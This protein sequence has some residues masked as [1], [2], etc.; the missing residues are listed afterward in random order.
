M[1]R[2]KAM[3]SADVF[4]SDSFLSLSIEAQALYPQLFFECDGWGTFSGV[5]G[6]LRSLGL[7][8]DTF[9]ELKEAGFV[10]EVEGFYVLTHWWV[11]NKL[12]KSNLSEGRHLDAL[13][14]NLCFH[15]ERNRIYEYQ[16]GSFPQMK[17]LPVGKKTS[18]SH[19]KAANRKEGN[20]TKP[21]TTKEKGTEP[22]G[23]DNAAEDNRCQEEE[24][25]NGREVWRETQE[26]PSGEPSLQSY[27]MDT[28]P[29]CG[30]L[31]P[32]S[33]NLLQTVIDCPACGTTT[34]ANETGELV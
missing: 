3:V 12:D 18:A 19:G 5:L 14:A 23:I 26:P 1:A 8:M 22:N 24:R 16:S 34:I 7:G 25:G 10:L 31:V 13:S 29:K 9:T 20:V 4:R 27:P 11:C 2:T 32:T 30:K 6:V 28:C 17:L 33:K 15:S 21:N